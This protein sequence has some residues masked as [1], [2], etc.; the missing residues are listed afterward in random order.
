MIKIFLVIYLS[1]W[2]F[3]PG[4]FLINHEYGTDSLLKKNNVHGPK[5]GLNDW[6]VAASD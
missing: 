2:P 1:L 6:N 3:R 4:S 5:Q